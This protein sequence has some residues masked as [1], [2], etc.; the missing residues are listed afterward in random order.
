MAVPSLPSALN[1]GDVVSNAW[2]DAVRNGLAFNRDDRPAIR[3]VLTAGGMGGISLATSVD[4]EMDFSNGSGAFNETP[5][6]NVDGFTAG[7]G[8]DLGVYVPETGLYH[9][10]GWATFEASATNTRAL[11]LLDEGAEIVGTRVNVGSNGSASIETGIATSAI[12]FFTAGDEL[13]LGVRQ[14]SGGTLSVDGALSAYWIN[15]AAS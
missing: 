2:V 11:W 6:V 9:I 14:N 1:N 8:G 12:R 4:G 7:T 13:G 5:S 15:S 3:I 10:Q